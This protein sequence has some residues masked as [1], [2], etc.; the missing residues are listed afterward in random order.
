MLNEDL[1]HKLCELVKIF[2]HPH[3]IIISLTKIPFLLCGKNSCVLTEKSVS[4]EETIVRVDP[5]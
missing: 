3:K 4:N 5:R 2:F 1:M